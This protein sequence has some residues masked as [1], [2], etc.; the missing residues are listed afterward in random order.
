MARSGAPRGTRP[1]RP[2]SAGRS[3]RR[4]RCPRPRGSAAPRAPE[5]RRRPA[6]SSSIASASI[7]VRSRPLPPR[8]EKVP[9]AAAVAVALEPGPGDRARSLHRAV[10]A[11]SASAAIAIVTTRPRS[12]PF[13][14]LQ[15]R[16]RCRARGARARPPRRSRRRPPRI[17]DR[18]GSRAATPN[19][20]VQPSP[21]LAR[22]EPAIENELGLGDEREGEPARREPLAEVGAVGRRGAGVGSEQV[23]HAVGEA[24]V[25]HRAR[26]ASAA[27]SPDEPGRQPVEADG[28][29]GHRH[30]AAVVEH[31]ELGAGNALDEAGG[32]GGGDEEVVPAPDD[33]RR[34][35]DLPEPVE[36]V[37]AG[38][39]RDRGQ[40]SRA[41]R[42]PAPSAR[43]GAPAAAGR[44]GAGSR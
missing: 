25:A 38:Q 33:Q 10:I 16:P 13:G 21:R 26:P 8:R 42:A 31:H 41:R 19:A 44:G 12:G 4:G 35:P 37:V 23:L 34:D 2:G 3:A 40:V 43:R 24:G 14:A 27:G 11:A 20:T 9:V 7:R 17:R 36:Q 15:S 29:L 30:V 39:G 18:R 22:K 5:V 1:R 28:P 32:V 6:R